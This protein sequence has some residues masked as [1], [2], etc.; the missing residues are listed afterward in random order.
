M[1]GYICVH[2]IT[3]GIGLKMY[4]MIILNGPFYIRYI[5]FLKR[6]EVYVSH[7]LYQKH[8]MIA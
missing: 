1:S 8:E 3:T 5:C 2:A 4:D 6:C 7:M